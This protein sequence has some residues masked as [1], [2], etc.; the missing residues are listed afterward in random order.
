MAEGWICLHRK[1]L[2]NGTVCRDAAHMAI[3]V[4]LLL[5]AEHEET[6]VLFGGERRVL[7][8]GELM[9]SVNKFAETYGIEK[10]KTWRILKRFEAEKQITICS[11]KQQTMIKI[12]EWG[13]YQFS[14]VSEKVRHEVRHEVRHGEHPENAD[15]TTAFGIAKNE[16]ETRSE[17]PS[18]TRAQKSEKEKKTFP[19]HPLIEKN[20]KPKKFKAPNKVYYNTECEP[21][22]SLQTEHIENNS[23]HKV[24]L[25][26]TVRTH[27][28]EKGETENALKKEIIDFFV[29]HGSDENTAKRFYDYNALKNPN[30]TD[31]KYFAGKWNKFERAPL[32]ALPRG[33]PKEKEKECGFDLDEF[34]ELAQRKGAESHEKADTQN[35]THAP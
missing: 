14:S 28:R 2:D 13:K 24:S 4:Y 19:P 3:W 16:S 31:W 20:K 34:F 17:T 1:M 7:K 18:E 30:F 12:T 25:R 15:V 29:G 11:D 6:E 23:V 21:K 9:I 27:A 22:F 10:N 33:Q 26:S 8:A 5:S 35:N 32:G